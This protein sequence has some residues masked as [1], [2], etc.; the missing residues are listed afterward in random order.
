MFTNSISI[1]VARN[2]LEPTIHEAPQPVRR[3][4]RILRQLRHWRANLASAIRP[5]KRRREDK[6]PET[7]GDAYE[8]GQPETGL[9]GMPDE[10]QLSLSF[11]PEHRLVLDLAVSLMLDLVV[12]PPSPTP[13]PTSSPT[14]SPTPSLSN[15]SDVTPA[16]TPSAEIL[17]FDDAATA[18]SAT[19]TASSPRC[20]LLRVDRLA[21]C[22]TSPVSPGHDEAPVYDEAPVSRQD[23]KVDALAN[24]LPLLSLEDDTTSVIDLDIQRQSIESNLVDPDFIPTTQHQDDEEPQHTDD[25]P[26]YNLE[27]IYEEEEEEDKEDLVDVASWDDEDSDDSDRDDNHNEYDNDN[28]DK[29]DNGK[30]FDLE[31]I[32]EDDEEDDE[33]C[34][35]LED[36]VHVFTWDDDEEDDIASSL[37]ERSSAPILLFDSEDEDDSDDEEAPLTLHWPIPVTAWDDDGDDD[38]AASLPERPS[39]P[40][41][42]L[43]REED[44]DYDDAA[45]AVQAHSLASVCSNDDDEDIAANLPERPPA[46]IPF[47]NSDDE[48]DEEASLTLHKPIVVTAWD[49]DEDDDIAFS[50]PER[51]SAP[52][53]FYF[54]EHDASLATVSVREINVMEPS[55]DSSNSSHNDDFLELNSSSNLSDSDN[56]EPMD[57]DLLPLVEPMEEKPLTLPEIQIN[58]IPLCLLDDAEECEAEHQHQHQHQREAALRLPQVRQ[59][60]A[61]RELFRSS[62][63]MVLRNDHSPVVLRKH[64]WVKKEFRR[65]TKAFAA[66]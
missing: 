20:R 44:D 40:L 19:S 1:P 59:R 18:P 3:G 50:L 17:T 62:P 30:G 38:I 13:S 58:G 8:P 2:A 28:D 7:R 5:G 24:L 57:D 31:T 42:F 27:T 12:S 25:A 29:K 53:P 46:P 26:P 6:E 39:A 43:D 49:N 35:A 64:V 32:Y 66:A 52:I 51:P 22:T 21:L 34:F 23:D 4:G 54:L 11:S 61:S 56:T 16:S 47:F 33:A 14:S 37:P 55:S 48:D 10:G 36:P 41:P 15:G 65:Q 45:S 63:R 9:I 60:G